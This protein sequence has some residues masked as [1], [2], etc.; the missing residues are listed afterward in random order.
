M[1]AS[2][3][4]QAAYGTAAR[5][6]AGEEFPTLLDFFVALRRRQFDGIADARL[7]AP[8]GLYETDPSAGGFMVPERYADGFISSLYEEA[9]IAPLV[10]AIT[11]T[12]P[13]LDVSITGIDETS[14]A[15]GSRWGGALSYWAAEGANV[16]ATKPRFKKINFSAGKLIAIAYTTEEMFRDSALFEAQMRKVFSAELSFKLDTAILSG[17]GAGMPAGILNAAALITVAKQA[18]Q[19]A[20]TI[21]QSN[22]SA[23]WARLPAP[24]RKRAVWLVNEDAESQFDDLNVGDGPNVYV[25]AGVHGNQYPLIKGRPVIAIEQAPV[26]GT[27]GDIVL[28]DLTQYM[29]IAAPPAFALSADAGFLTDELVMRFTLRIDGQPE[30]SSALAPYNG[31]PTRSPF[32]TLAAR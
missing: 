14:R 16:S 30:W 12:G 10:D 27:V 23:M 1:P 3:L 7:R 22:I 11:L 21:V 6:I 18:G 17:T 5:H 31:A 4:K 15:D 9:E 2:N 24:C 19:A 8:T 28:T 13:I 29:T 20:G 25:P 26:L 32:I